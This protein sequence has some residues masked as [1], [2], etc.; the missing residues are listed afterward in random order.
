MNQHGRMLYPNSE[1]L[2]FLSPLN[3]HQYQVYCIV[4]SRYL[5]YWARGPF[6][7]AFR[8]NGDKTVYVLAQKDLF[9]E[10]D[11][12]DYLKWANFENMGTGFFEV[13]WD[14]LV[15]VLNDRESL[16]A[17]VVFVTSNVQDETWNFFRYYWENYF[18]SFPIKPD[19]Q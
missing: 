3:R 19:W 5:N 9:P 18:S 13:D 10:F 7:M 16:I 17:E 8:F 14:N 11:A 12:L 4:S 15:G 6:R 2:S 1:L